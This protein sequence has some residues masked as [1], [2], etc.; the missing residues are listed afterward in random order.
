MRPYGCLHEVGRKQDDWRRQMGST[1]P[2][3]SV[4]VVGPP[5]CPPP[6]TDPLRHHIL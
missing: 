5:V 1:G 3:H 2:H 4:Q 6:P